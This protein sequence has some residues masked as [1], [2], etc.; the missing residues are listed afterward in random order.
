[1]SQ[2][3]AERPGDERPGEDGVIRLWDNANIVESFPEI[4]LPL[5]FSVAVELYASVYRT[6]CRALG[7]P[8][9]AIDRNSPAFEEMLGLLHGRVYYNLG[10][11]YQVLALLP[12]FRLNAGFLEAMMGTDRPGGRSGEVAEV[13]RPGPRR[14]WEL[15]SS[16]GRL[17]WRYLRCGADASRF[18][19]A[20][21]GLIERVR[22]VPPAG[23]SAEQLLADF[24]EVTAEALRH[25]RAPIMNDLFLMITNGLLRRLAGS[26]LGADAQRLVTAVLAGTNASSAR[27]GRDLRRLAAEIEA[28][29]TWRQA[30]LTSPADALLA[31]L[32]SDPELAGLRVL[33]DGY[34]DTWGERSPRELQFE[35]ATF[36]EDPVPLVRAVVA[37]VGAGAEPQR[38]TD[39]DAARL[40]RRRLLRHPLGP[41]RLAAFWVLVRATRR[42]VA[43]RESMRLARGQV[44]GIGRGIFRR[45]GADL[46]ERAVLG[47]ADD[48]HCLTI[49]E[50]R[51]AVR[52]RTGTT[53]LRDLVARRRA[54]FAAFASRPPLP[55]RFETR[56]PITDP[57]RTVAGMRALPATRTDAEWT[58]IAAS[59]GRVRGRCVVVED[60]SRTTPEAGRIVV[61]RTMDPGWVPIIVGA[62][63]LLVEQ[64]S[65]LSHSAIVARELG[66]PMVV[67]IPGLVDAV[68]TGDVI[69]LDGTTGAVR[70][71]PGIEAAA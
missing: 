52:G 18:R 47:A 30:A 26:W 11:W 12:G 29:P 38:P 66:I 13:V 69:D 22:T 17:A 36:R 34:L 42:H 46:A 48:V 40:L 64:G 54:E 67:R 63:G 51:E 59:P 6:A 15:A 3:R 55:S 20:I 65:M 23:R 71:E 49:G 2:R 32:A 56:G 28:R 1:M 57:V 31:R 19:A 70:L 9:G 62:A 45:I 43:Q 24:D 8:Q 4:T 53:E 7:V 44:F 37:L 41:A 68:R 35:R 50:L 58:G 16:S 60:P 21:A 14:T 61:A 10:S 27:A 39:R 5:T 25:W 33:I